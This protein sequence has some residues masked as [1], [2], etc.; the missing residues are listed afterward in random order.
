MGC[1]PWSFDLL[2]TNTWRAL[3]RILGVLTI[4]MLLVV[5]TLRRTAAVRVVGELRGAGW[6]RVLTPAETGQDTDEEH[7]QRR[8]VR[9]ELKP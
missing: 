4:S 2:D 6:A 5:G 3:L 7:L 8:C 1:F 9:A